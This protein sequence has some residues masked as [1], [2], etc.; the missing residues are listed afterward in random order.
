MPGGYLQLNSYK[1]NNSFLTINPQKTF[2]RKTYHQYNNFA[3]I[4][5][6]L[7][8]RSMKGRAY[9][10]KKNK[11]T[12]ILPKYGDLIKEF[13]IQITLPK[14]I[15]GGFSEIKWIKDLQF[16]I[17][18]SIKFK[19][20]GKTIQEFDSEL[21]YLRRE[22]LLNMEKKALGNT[23]SCNYMGFGKT[24]IP[25]T[26]LFI[27]IP[28][29]FFDV[30]FPIT[31]L[32]LVNFEIDININSIFDLL[33]VRENN[34][35]NLSGTEFNRHPWRRL[36]TH[37]Y[38]QIVPVNFQIKPT[39]KMNYIF[40]EESELKNYF[41]FDNRI[42]IE[43]HNRIMLKDVK[44]HQTYN[45]KENLLEYSYDTFGCTR[46]ITVL[47]RKKT[48]TC[49][50]NQHFNFT[51]LDNIEKANVHIF[52]N[53][54]LKTAIEDCS[55]GDLLSYIEDF[56]NDVQGTTKALSINKYPK[57][58]QDGISTGFSGTI[59]VDYEDAFR[60]VEVKTIREQWEFRDISGALNNIPI[61]TDTFNRNI[62][63]SIQ[64]KFNNIERQ[65]Y[66]T[67]SFYQELELFKNYPSNNNNSIYTINFA[68]APDQKKPSG[69]CNLSHIRD[70]RL[71]LKL[72]L[73]TN[74]DYEMILYNCY[75]NILQ[76]HSG[77][78]NFMFY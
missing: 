54:L 53:K 55:G 69:Q 59:H 68:L 50:Y 32:D 18:E 29:W 2:F 35:V 36:H 20:G 41:V 48:N 75:Y 57:L 73:D 1:T 47:M 11:F 12:I 26:T 61:V 19:I 25:E 63:D 14:L 52:Q 67:A 30:P 78:T 27:P 46:S 66:Q 45:K 21:L 42:L 8:C 60:G 28:V 16:K 39:I 44:N 72:N 3:K 34:L 62:I 10:N 4:N 76:L 71:N 49:Q 9:F 74:E 33:L 37:E 13:Y 31:C 23:L 6:S 15:T 51:N 58:Y 77:S 43:R 40:L 7:E 22:L 5:F 65:E 38:D 17:I 70:V 64:I 24:Y 56:T